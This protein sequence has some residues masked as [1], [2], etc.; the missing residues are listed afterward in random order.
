MLNTPEVHTLFSHPLASFLSTAAPSSHAASPS[1]M[2]ML[3]PDSS[4]Q[5]EQAAFELPYHTYNDIPWPPGGG[6]WHPTST[7]RHDRS[8]GSSQDARRRRRHTEADILSGVNDL[9]VDDAQ[10]YV[11][12]HRFLTGREQ[13]GVKPVY[14]MTAYTPF[15]T[16]RAIMSLTLNP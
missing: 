15:S 5:L 8:S 7:R 13:G 6:R 16:F 2:D 12:M 11:R 14:G 4:T 10:Q 9:N 1:S 3:L